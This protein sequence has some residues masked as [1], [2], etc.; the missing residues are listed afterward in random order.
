MDS[1]SI[2]FEKKV[3]P[4]FDAAYNLARWLTRDASD[5]E[6]V[7]QEAFMRA[8]KYSSG[9]RGGRQRIMDTSNRSQFMTA[10]KSDSRFGARTYLRYLRG[11]IL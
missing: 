2:E 4:H 11:K 7:V 9:L 1:S 10:K 8:F 5:A 6:D 3:L